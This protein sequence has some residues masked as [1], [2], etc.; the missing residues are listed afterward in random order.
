[1]L[2]P[3]AHC[4]LTHLTIVRH[5]LLRSKQDWNFFFVYHL[6]AENT[7]HKFAPF[8]TKV[9]LQL[10]LTYCIY[11]LGPSILW[12][13]STSAESLSQ[14]LLPLP[15]RLATHPSRLCRLY[16]APPLC[17]SF[18]SHALV[19]HEYVTRAGMCTVVDRTGG[20]CVCSGQLR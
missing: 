12:S 18:V 2:N 19:W 1:M 8:R 4:N 11:M 15:C 17:P 6:R 16:Y 20:S 9:L 10:N 3:L 7:G 5:Y 14:P 13:A